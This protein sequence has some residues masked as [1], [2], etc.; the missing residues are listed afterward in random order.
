MRRASGHRGGGIGAGP[1]RRKRGVA[2]DSTS[3][4]PEFGVVAGNSTELRTLAP[5]PRARR[6]I[7]APPPPRPPP[8]GTPRTPPLPGRP[9]P[10]LRPPPTHRRGSAHTLPPP[11][12]PPS[13]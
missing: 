2:G 13:P 5:C 11:L 8:R 12:Q 9:C 10:D 6:G 7:H 4:R 3:G 1:V